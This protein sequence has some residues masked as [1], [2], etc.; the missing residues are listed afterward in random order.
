MTN[1]EYDYTDADV[2]Y[3]SPEDYA[4]EGDDEYEDAPRT[5]TVRGNVYEVK[6]TKGRID[7]Y[8]QRH[9]PIMASF[10]SNGGAFSS[11]E[12]SD[13]MAYGLCAQ[14]GKYIN[15]R[16]GLEMA[17]QLL[18][19]SGYLAVYEAVIE[20]LQRDCGFLFQGA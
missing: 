17:E 1:N 5:F 19:H 2:D 15:P 4:Y 3:E 13:L 6:F 12:L 10:V 16:R 8:E 18:I 20:A 7:L 9:K 11:K 14:G